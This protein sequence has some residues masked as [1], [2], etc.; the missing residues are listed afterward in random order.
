M[1]PPATAEMIEAARWNPILNVFDEPGVRFSLEV[2]P[3]EIAY[4]YWTT[5]RTL[6]AIGHRAPSAFNW[7]PSHMVWQDLD[8]AG[9]ILEIADRIYHVD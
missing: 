8:P 3:S 7:N 9:F 2:H 6:D 5:R 1:F 4:D